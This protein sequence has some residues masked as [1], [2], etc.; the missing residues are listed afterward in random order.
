MDEPGSLC[1]SLAMLQE[2]LRRFAGTL[3]AVTGVLAL[4]L[5]L[6]LMAD[7]FL[8]KRSPTSLISLKAR[9]NN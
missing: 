1:Q 3:L 5:F 9:L 2:T 4:L 8:L 6:Q 7:E